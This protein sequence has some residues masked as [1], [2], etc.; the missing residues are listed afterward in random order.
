MLFQVSY[1]SDLT[2]ANVVCY[3]G[4]LYNITRIDTLQE[5]NEDST[6]FCVAKKKSRNRDIILKS[7]PCCATL[8]MA[9]YSHAQEGYFHDLQR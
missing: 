7:T 5:Y 4:T 2:T 6:L 3:N 1:H 8:S 9:D